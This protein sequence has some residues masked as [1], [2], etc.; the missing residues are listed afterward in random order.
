MSPIAIGG[1]TRSVDREAWALRIALTLMLAIM[2]AAIL[3]PLWSILSKSV[4][5]RAGAFVGLA[6]Y[7]QFFGTPALA[8]SI[9]NSLFVAGLTTLIVVPLAFVYAYALTRTCMPA[10]GLMAGIALI[11]ILS[12][13]M[14]PAIALIYLFGNQGM[15]RE[16][17]FGETIYGPIGIVMG[18]VFYC[19]PHAMLILTTALSLA[20]ARLY[21]AAAALG[22]PRRRVFLTV[23]LPSA[24]YGLVSAAFVVFTLVMTD[25]GIPVVIGGR[26]NVL[27]IDVYKQVMGQQ[28]FQMGAV[29]AVVLIIPALASFVVDRVVQRRQVALLGARSVPLVPQPQPARDWAMLGFCAVVGAIILGILATAVFASLV[30]LWPYNLS[31]GWSNY[32]FEDFDSDGW[33]SYFNSLRMAA[34]TAVFGTLFVFVGAYLVEKGKGAGWAR[35]VFHLVAMVPLAVPGLVLGLAYVFFFNAP[36]NPLGGLYGTMAL[37]TICTVA[38]FYTVAH[39]TATTALKQMDPE[40]ESVSASLQVPFWRT[41]L[42]VTV[43][44]CLPAIVNIAIYLFV[45]AMTTVSAVI[46]IYTAHTKLASVAIVNMNDSGAIAAAAAMAVVITATSAGVKLVET[47]VSRVVL[48]RSQRWRAR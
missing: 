24:K 47:L 15:I 23:T 26:F 39:L 17:L 35:Q 48:R 11:P 31:L 21:E 2:A 34:A 1:R 14:L 38:H 19:F 27:A 5:D 22:T 6:N 44:V 30:R 7:A 3:L 33:S 16:L 9:A 32:V 25:F 13:S 29:V 18:Q 8:Q 10:K 41:F 45:N 20:D 4:E 40:F 28:N 42:R 46:F 36:D 43:P 12:P 37:L